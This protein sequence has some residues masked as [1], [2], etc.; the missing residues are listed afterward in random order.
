MMRYRHI[1]SRILLGSEASFHNKARRWLY[2]GFVVS[3]LLVIGA[4]TWHASA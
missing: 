2:G 3:V 4:L 1:V